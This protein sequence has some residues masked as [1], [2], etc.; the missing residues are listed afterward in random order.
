MI[1]KARDGGCRLIILK[2]KNRDTALKKLVRGR[3]KNKIHMV[4]D[5]ARER[6]VEPN[7]TIFDKRMGK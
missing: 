3:F 2:C 4:G 7:A 5:G 1:T 6:S